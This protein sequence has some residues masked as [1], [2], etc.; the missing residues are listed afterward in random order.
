[1]LKITISLFKIFFLR[2]NV[3]K[4]S[5]LSMLIL[6]ASTFASS[7]N[8]LN[9]YI[10]SGDLPDSVIKQFERETGIKVNYSSYDSNETLYAK[11]LAVKNAGYDIVQP[12]SYYISRMR[13]KGMLQPID[14]TKIPNLKYLSPTV[15]NPP[16]D[17]HRQYTIPGLW[18]VT[19]IFVNKQYYDPKTI[20]TWKDFWN[21]KY[22][23]KLLL[24]DDVREVFSI[25]LISL[26][27]SPN[28]DKPKDIK[29]AYEHLIKLQKNIKLFANNAVPAIIADDDAVIGMGWNGDIFS[30][31]QDN[32]NLVFIYPE[33]GFVA[34]SDDFAIIKSA[35][36]VNN[37]YKFLNFIERP[38]INAKIIKEMGYPTGN[39]AAKNYLSHKEKQSTTLFPPDSVMKH[40]IWQRDINDKAI[41]LYSH[42]WEKLKLMG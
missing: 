7:D 14:K 2:N 33:D 28:T 42:Y 32:P 9:I 25:A 1:M 15:M 34:W 12:S 29:T 27:L 31:S 26:G 35:P 30:A 22:N 8:I 16:Y 21:K 37:A 13:D 4:L 24:L 3:L 19:G 39:I 38:D 6:T 18:G 17:P 5:I 20:H 23:N 10:W 40:A 11:L 36:H 41:A